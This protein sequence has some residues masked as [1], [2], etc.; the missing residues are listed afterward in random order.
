MFLHVAGE[1]TL[2]LHMDTATTAFDSARTLYNH[3]SDDNNDTVNG[4]GNGELQCGDVCRLSELEAQVLAHRPIAVGDSKK[5]RVLQLMTTA[6]T[7]STLI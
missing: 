5:R 2:K 6:Q 1:S 7:V 4:D 3:D